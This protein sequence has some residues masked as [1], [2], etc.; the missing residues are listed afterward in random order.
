MRAAL[1]PTI[2]QR[3]LWGQ[4]TWQEVEGVLDNLLLALC[5]WGYRPGALIVSSLVLEKSSLIYDKV[6]DVVDSLYALLP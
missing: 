2:H 1:V 4:E 3:V 6:S 5:R